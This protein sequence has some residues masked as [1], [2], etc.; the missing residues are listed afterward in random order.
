M[1]RRENKQ[2]FFC[3]ASFINKT[4]LINAEGMENKKKQYS[5]MRIIRM[6][7]QAAGGEIE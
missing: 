6:H 4:N 7:S 3:S 5:I 2:S 1:N